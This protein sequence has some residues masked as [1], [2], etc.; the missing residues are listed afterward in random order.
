MKNQKHVMFTGGGMSII[1]I[2]LLLVSCSKIQKNEMPVT[3]QSKQALQLFLDGRDNWEN[4]EFTKAF[5]LLSKATKMDS[6]FAQAYIYKAFCMG[7]TGNPN[8]FIK[9]FNN[10]LK[11]M[12]HA[13][14]GE[15]AF[16]SYIK[17]INEGDGPKQQ[18]LIEQLLTLFPEDKRIL[19][20]AGNHYTLMNDFQIAKEYYEKALLLDKNYTRIYNDLGYT[21]SSLNENQKAEETFKTYISL[22]PDKANPYDSYAEL[23]LKL[24]R[25]DESIG[26]YQKALEVDPTFLRAY[27]GIGNN[28]IFKGDFEQARNSYQQRL[29][30]ATQFG[31]KLG[32]LYLQAVSYIHQGD[33]NAAMAILNNR[34]EL[35]QKENQMT[36]VLF[37]YLTDAKTLMELGNPA[38]GLKQVQTAM[39]LITSLELD[40]WIKENLTVAA[41]EMMCNCKIH[42]NKLEEAKVDVDKF[43]Q[44]INKRQDP[45]NIMQLESTLALLALKE[46]QYDQALEHFAKAD[47]QSPLNWYYMA[48]AYEQKGDADNARQLLEKISTWTTNN[49]NLA[50][51]RNR[52]IDQ[53]KTL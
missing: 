31:D 42:D 40:D 1:L 3:T 53:L 39:D 15:K 23:L 22:I 6:N 51:V 36:T 26:Q 2:L 14:E 25:Y 33:L 41:M 47:N 21:Y 10:A 18:E 4:L 9:A 5:D 43:K 32:A 17:A 49:L 28:F 30:K 34:R 38:E 8:E 46:K 27:D 45:E 24:G 19:V 48:L 12:D 20:F 50:L 13:S 16:I 37:S 35:A 7:G 11:A 52:A 29:D 44:L